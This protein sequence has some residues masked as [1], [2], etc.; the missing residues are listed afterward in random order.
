MSTIRRLRLLSNMSQ[1][2]L[3]QKLNISQAYLSLLERDKAPVTPA[4]AKKLD[5]VFG[6][7]IKFF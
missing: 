2:Q 7:S 5:E 4:I 6:F 3:A 1:G